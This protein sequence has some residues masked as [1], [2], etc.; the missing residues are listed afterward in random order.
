MQNNKGSNASSASQGPAVRVGGIGVG[1]RPMGVVEKPKN[2]KNTII[3]IWKYFEG[4]Q[5]L[6]FLILIFMIISAVIG[7][8]IPYLIGKSVD[9]MGVAQGDI[10]FGIL[11]TIVMAL[12]LA[13][14]VDAFMNFLQSYTLAGVSQR[15]VRKLRTALFAKLQSLPISFFDLRSNGDIMSRL[16]N[17]IDNVSTT[18]S[19]ATLQLMS[20][21]I[22]IIGAFSMMIYLS[23]LLT[24]A[25]IITIPLVFLLTKTVAKKTKPLFKAQQAELGKLNGN[26]EESIS[27]IFVVKAF[28]HEEKIIEEFKQMNNK[29]CEIG[30]K[31]QVLSGLMMPLMNVINNLGFTVV[32]AV[33][34]VLAVNG[35]IT[36]GIISSFIIYSRQFSRPLNDFANVLNTLQSAVAGAERVF[37]ILDEVEE[38]EDSERAIEIMNT[39][40]EVVFE[41]VSFGYRENV[42]ILKDISFR[43]KEGSTIALVGP[44]GAGKTTIVNLLTRFYDV[45]SGKIL[46]D[47]VDI[48]EYKRD[49]L[50]QIF[51][52]VLQDTYLFSGT[53]RENIRYGKLEA[54]D[55]EVEQASIMANADAFIRRMPRGYDTVL[56]ESGS[57]LSQGQKQLLAI[58]RAILS[59][60][61]IL[62]LDEATSSVD[63]RTELNIQEAMLKLMKGRTSFIIAHRLST[64]RDADII[65][66]IDN[67]EIIEKGSHEELICKEGVYYNMHS[68]QLK[69]EY[70]N[71]RFS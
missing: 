26:I 32:A 25:S 13:Y 66:V 8:T 67:G 29:L 45:T 62:I 48:R 42:T 22:A 20:G 4:E 5:K 28:N 40:G 52:I 23:P 58:A 37:E 63:T 10:D 69:K 11:A 64:I 71:E 44:T 34:G 24:L 61:S 30:I 1:R 2:F 31:A 43:A 7:V 68:K 36:V 15:I 12:L 49:S 65:M 60:P 59:N 55:N 35:I 3:R 9:T 53:I 19:Q 57:N 33:G 18:I 51:G 47:G 17:D 38:R 50:R 56:S 70:E 41:D 6:L 16:A 46:I 21:A 39:R 14:V 54:T 27:G